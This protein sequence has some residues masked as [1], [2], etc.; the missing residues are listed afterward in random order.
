MVTLE[1]GN[2]SWFRYPTHN[3]GTYLGRGVHVDAQKTLIPI[4]LY[5]DLK[6]LFVGC[7]DSDIGQWEKLH[8]QQRANS[9]LK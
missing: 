8:C 2:L 5:I 7:K 4:F 1:R 3:I 9:V 6:S